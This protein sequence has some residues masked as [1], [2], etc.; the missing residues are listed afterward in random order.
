MVARG[1]IFRAV[2]RDVIKMTYYILYT[3]SSGSTE[4]DYNCLVLSGA[5]MGG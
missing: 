5:A 3:N 4:F 2:K 1:T